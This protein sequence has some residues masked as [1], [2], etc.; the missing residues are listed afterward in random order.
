M[1]IILGIAGI[2]A[3]INLF[4]VH[5][6]IQ[7]PKAA[8]VSD[9]TDPRQIGATI[10][11]KKAADIDEAAKKTAFDL[12]N[13]A[14]ATAQATTADANQ[15]LRTDLALVGAPVYVM[16]GAT[17]VEVWMSDT[18]DPGFKVFRPLP[19]ETPVPVTP[20]APAPDA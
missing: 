16:E 10:A 7:R 5:P 8:P 6:S 13:T 18:A 19:S 9:S 20:P 2:L 15:A 17:G 4:F 12:A 14:Y 1:S 3:L 11:A